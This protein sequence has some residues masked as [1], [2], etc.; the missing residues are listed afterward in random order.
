MVHFLELSKF[1]KLQQKDYKE[2]AIERWLV[3]MD[4]RDI[5]EITLKELMDMDPAIC[6]A[7]NKL[8]HLS[9]D[10]KTMDLYLERERSLGLLEEVVKKL[11]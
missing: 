1:R 3:L 9:S 10:P 4:N 7:V 6:K 8:K 11:R 5:P 2:N